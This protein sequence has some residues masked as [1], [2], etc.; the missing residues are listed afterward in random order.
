[1]RLLWALTSTRQLDSGVLVLQ[2]KPP[3]MVQTCRISLAMEEDQPW[4]SLQESKEAD[5]KLIATKWE[6]IL[7]WVLKVLKPLMLILMTTTKLT[8][9]SLMLSELKS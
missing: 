5:S 7:E 9:L 8:S 4:N 1:M 3:Q 6:L 2:L